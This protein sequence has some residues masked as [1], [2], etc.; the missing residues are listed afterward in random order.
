[1]TYSRLRRRTLDGADALNV[2]SHLFNSVY[3]KPTFFDLHMPMPMPRAKGSSDIL[4]NKKLNPMILPTFCHIIEIILNW[5]DTCT[6]PE[7]N[8]KENI[9][10]QSQLAH[11]I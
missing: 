2:F 4:P 7:L 10:G 8:P 9:L 5:Y 6:Y 3:N 11:R 1:M